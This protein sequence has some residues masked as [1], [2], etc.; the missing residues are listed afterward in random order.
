[1]HE[2]TWEGRKEGL[3]EQLGG[4]LKKEKVIGNGEGGQR[5]KVI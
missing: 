3:K 1:M 2:V 5:E 4:R